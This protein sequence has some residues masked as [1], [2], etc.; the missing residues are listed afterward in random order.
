MTKSQAKERIGKLRKEIEHHRYLYHVLDRQE[1][2][3]AALDSLKHELAELEARYP[4]L[5]TPDSPTQRVGGEPLPA[6]MKVRHAAPML[7]LNDVFAAEEVRAWEERVKKLLGAGAAPEY[8]AELKM[9]GLALSLIY[10]KGVLVRAATR[11]DGRVGEDVTQNVRTVESVPLTLHEEEL[12]TEAARKAARKRVEVRGE[13]VIRRS[14]FEKLNKDLKA[15]GEPEFANP[16]NAA[17]GAV[18]QLD[19][20]V[21]ASRRLD[22]YAYDVPTDLGQET[23]E[24]AHWF[25][26][27]LGFKIVEQDHRAKDLSAVFPFLARVEKERGAYDYNSDGVVITVND[28][29][30]FRKLGAVGKAPRGAIAY[31]YPAEEATTA[32]EEI[33]VQ[34]GRTG[35]L[36]PVAHLRPVRVAGTTVSRATLHNADEI[37]RLDVRKGD[38]VIVRKAGDIIPDVVRVLKDLRTGKEKRFSMPRRCP[39]CR[40]EVRRKEG[41]A[42]HYCTNADCPARHRESLYH[43]VSK[44]ALDIAHLGPSTID[45]L[46][47]EGLVQEPA[48]LFRLTAEGLKALP[49]FQEKKAENVIRAISERKRVPLGRF[50]Y[51]LGIRHVG[52]ETAQ[53]LA[54]SF[55][56][57]EKVIDAKQEDFEAQHDIGGVVAESLAGYFQDQKN[58][59]R[60]EHLLDAGL[61]FKKEKQ[62]RRTP[63]FGKSV[64]VTGSLEQ[65]TRE[66]AHEAIRAAGGSPSSSVSA[67]TDYVLVGADPGTKA[68]KAKKLGIRTITEKE[69]LTLIR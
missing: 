10:E 48:D 58:R 68:E 36:T 54:A 7:S 34:V 67:Q 5:V 52:E 38:T 2:S 63:L 12:P 4:G 1:I 20:N 16:R 40:G 66:S 61:T 45:A 30:L 17:A 21:T 56:A 33:A 8:F 35:A 64:V 44:K 60:I 11:G 9:D 18:R 13:V 69:F 27:L 51:A 62:K 24:D 59:K 32:V 53:D 25:A 57:L 49:L 19:P 3:D 47:E 23:H 31:K 46:V 28:R 22:F 15:R 41:E 29:A 42:I 37:A 6:F 14:V 65:F 26:H 39:V 50:L 43:F 55:G